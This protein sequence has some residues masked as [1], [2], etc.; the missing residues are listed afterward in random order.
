MKTFLQ[1]LALII[2][3]IIITS[4]SAFQSHQKINLAPFAENAVDIVS[5]VEY[6]LSQARVIHIR[7]Y[8]DGPKVAKYRQRWVR[9]GGLLKGIVAYSVQVVTIA[10]SDLSG[11]DRAN[12]LAD[13]IAVLGAPAISDPTLGFK[14]TRE[15]FN[16][17]IEDMRLQKDYLMSLNSAQPIVDEVARVARQFVWI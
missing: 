16:S 13:Y 15:E 3:T 17:V 12:L 10:Q 9:L 14:I 4:C 1:P 6:G 2:S 7:P 11:N 5:E 8:I